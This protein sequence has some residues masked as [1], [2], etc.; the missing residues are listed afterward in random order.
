MAL[1]LSAR[2]EKYLPFYWPLGVRSAGPVS[3]TYMTATPANRKMTPAC[4]EA[5]CK[6]ARRNTPWRHAGPSG[7]Y[8]GHPLLGPLDG[9]WVSRKPRVRRVELRSRVPPK[10]PN[11]PRNH[12]APLGG[13]GL[14]PMPGRQ[15]DGPAA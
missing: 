3:I 6:S 4:A 14:G 8:D 10:I 1:V 9:L 12:E 11:R 2:L 13:P 15:S 7:T 5:C